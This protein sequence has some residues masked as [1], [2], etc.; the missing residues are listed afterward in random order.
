V[1][2]EKAKRWLE[3]LEKGR[4]LMEGWPKYYV[5]LKDGA[6]E[7]YISSP[8]TRRHTAGGTAA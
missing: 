2:E 7:V 5:G 4:T 1:G 3:K 8:P 6:L